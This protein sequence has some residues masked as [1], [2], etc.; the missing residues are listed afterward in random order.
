MTNLI[1]VNTGQTYADPFHTWSHR[2]MH[3]H[4][5]SHHLI[6][7]LL[8]TPSI[9]CP[10]IERQHPGHPKGTMYWIQRFVPTGT[11]SMIWTHNFPK[12]KQGTKQYR[13][14]FPM[15]S[16]HIADL[17]N[18][19][20]VLRLQRRMLWD[21]LCPFLQFF[22]SDANTAQGSIKFNPQCFVAL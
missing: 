4:F 17:L 6:R 9:V 13:I 2:P 3:S 15:I 22:L 10:R 18:Q 21:F 19:S 20:F 7:L 5:P 14:L 16:T 8:F 11:E 12:L 1:R